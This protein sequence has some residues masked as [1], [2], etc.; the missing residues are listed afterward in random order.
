[1]RV[2]GQYRRC[3]VA[4]IEVAHFAVAQREETANALGLGIDL[5]LIRR[6]AII[7]EFLHQPIIGRGHDRVLRR[8]P[9]QL[10]QRHDRHRKDVA[11][12]P[13]VLLRRIFFLVLPHRFE[14][15]R[16]HHPHRY[17]RR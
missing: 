2:M 15:D 10:F 3:D 7:R 16:E 5:Q 13:Q 1:M 14:V 11:P 12:S 6:A 8:A 9:L 4:F 17:L